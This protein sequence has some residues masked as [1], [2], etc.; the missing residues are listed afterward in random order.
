LSVIR[1]QGKHL[2]SVGLNGFIN[3]LDVNTPDRPLRIVKVGSRWCLALLTSLQGA[4]KPVTS[5]CAK[6]ETGHF[7]AGSYDGTVWSL[8]AR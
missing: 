3:Y 4:V 2:L 7:Y 8:L 5:M 1:S 6:P